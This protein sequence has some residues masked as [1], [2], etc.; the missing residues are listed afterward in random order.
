MTRVPTFANVGIEFDVAEELES[1]LFRRT[2]STTFTEGI[3]L[4]IAMRAHEVAHVLDHADHFYLHLAEHLDG[5]AR[6]LQRY[7]ARRGDHDRSRH[8]HGLHQRDHDVS[9]AWRQIDDQV[10]EFS[11]LH[12]REELLDDGVQHRPAPHQRL[13]SWI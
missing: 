10:I 7:V 8:R 6:V 13:V 3:D 1:K 5:L 11:P 2:L 9:R 12:L 4:M